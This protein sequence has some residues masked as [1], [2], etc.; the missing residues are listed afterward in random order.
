VDRASEGLRQ[1][2]R[3]DQQEQAPR[4]ADKA[5][6]LESSVEQLEELIVETTQ[7]L[8]VSQWRAAACRHRLAC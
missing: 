6:A 2:L 8:Q 3:P 1:L 4:S 5:A 7:L